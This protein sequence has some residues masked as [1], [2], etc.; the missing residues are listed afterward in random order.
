MTISSVKEFRDRATKLLRSKDPI[1]VMRRGQLAGIFFPCPE[2]SIPLELKRELFPVLAS[3]VARQIKKKG[4]TED[5][6]VNGFR[7][8]RRR[9]RPRDAALKV[10]A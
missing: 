6:L 10:G 7:E 9:R 1:L 3:E 5:D 4:L 2:K 8:W